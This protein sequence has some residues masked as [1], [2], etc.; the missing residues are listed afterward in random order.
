M[1][2]DPLSLGQ[3]LIA[4]FATLGI[5]LLMLIVFWCIR[6]ALKARMPQYREM[7]VGLFQTVVIPQSR[8]T[9]QSSTTAQ[10]EGQTVQQTRDLPPSYSTVMQ[11]PEIYLVYA[12]QYTTVTENQLR[13]ESAPPYSTVMKNQQEYLNVCSYLTAM[14]NQQ[15]CLNAPP[16]VTVSTDQDAP[17][18]STSADN[19]P[20][21][22]SLSDNSQRTKQ[23][24]F[25][26]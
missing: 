15:E 22:L 23:L 20:S 1:E 2:L 11:N 3:K 17:P 7:H 18:N 4:I 24:N 13:Y 16:Y 25:Y 12:P 10:T 26:I 5:I 9:R 14:G 6:T 8:V 19:Q 21:H